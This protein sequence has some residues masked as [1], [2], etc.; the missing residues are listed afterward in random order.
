MPTPATDNGV[1]SEA[2]AATT[3]DDGSHDE[4]R[5]DDSDRDH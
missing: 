2:V 3:P 4:D 5:D 1:A